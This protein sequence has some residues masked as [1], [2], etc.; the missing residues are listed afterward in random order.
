MSLIILIIHVDRGE[1]RRSLCYI[2]PTRM[3]LAT[4]L[5]EILIVQSVLILANQQAHTY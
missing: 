5:A 4:L 2:E 1:L 3:T